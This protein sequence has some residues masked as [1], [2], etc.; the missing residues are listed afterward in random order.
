MLY[1]DNLV[2]KLDQIVKNNVGASWGASDALHDVPHHG[3][4]WGASHA[5]MIPHVIFWQFGEKI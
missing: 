2:K 5:H 1:F 3:A 4:S